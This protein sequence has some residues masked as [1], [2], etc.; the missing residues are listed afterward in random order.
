MNRGFKLKH[1]YSR[2]SDRAAMN[3]ITLISVA[4]MITSLVML[5]D[6]V[7][8]TYFY[9]DPKETNISIIDDLASKVRTPL[10]LKIIEKLQNHVPLVTTFTRKMP[11]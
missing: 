5:S 10:V 8:R 3:Y 7:Q 2:K 4:D 9:D 1:K 11:L 6:W